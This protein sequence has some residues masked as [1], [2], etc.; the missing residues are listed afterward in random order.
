MLCGE[1]E[2]HGYMVS[3]FGW[4]QTSIKIYGLFHWLNLNSAQWAS[5]SPCKERLSV[6]SQG[7]AAQ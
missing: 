2:S 4:R 7:I 5:L 3:F 6:S 1:I